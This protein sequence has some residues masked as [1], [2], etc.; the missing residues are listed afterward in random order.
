MLTTTPRRSLEVFTFCCSDLIRP[1]RKSI[2]SG[3]F[4]FSGFTKIGLRFSG[5]WI[6][7]NTNP[8]TL[9]RVGEKFFNIVTD[10]LKISYIQ[11][12][13]DLK[14]FSLSS[15]PCVASE[16][17]LVEINKSGLPLKLKFINKMDKQGPTWL[18][19]SRPFQWKI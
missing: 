2:K 6:F 3:N 14:Y 19:Q 12:T 13:E 11:A 5:F 18:D 1:D 7:L 4:F 17:Y 9:H 16:P 15:S 10:L 8:S